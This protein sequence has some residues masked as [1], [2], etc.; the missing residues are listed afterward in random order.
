MDYSHT[1]PTDLRCPSCN[2]PFTVAVWL[3]VDE[4]AQPR[5]IQE[6]INGQLNRFSCPHCHQP[7]EA[8]EPLLVYRPN[9]QPPLLFSPATKTAIAEDQSHDL[10]QLVKRLLD[11][12]D[13]SD[14]DWVMEGLK[15]VPRNRLP[16]MLH[17]DHL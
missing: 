5:L 7:V 15:R 14:D 2:Q 4:P 17:E 10:Q 6:L 11:A 13:S 9:K 12:L 3:I 8:D 1:K 16:G